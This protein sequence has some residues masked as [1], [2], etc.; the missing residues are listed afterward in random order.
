MLTSF[1]CSLDHHLRNCG[2]DRS[3]SEH[4]EFAGSRGSETKAKES[5][6][7]GKGAKKNAVEPLSVAGQGEA[8]GVKAARGSFSTST[9]MHSLVLYNNA[10][11]LEGTRLT[12]SGMHATVTFGVVSSGDGR[13]HIESSVKHGS[14]TH[15]CGIW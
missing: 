3:I 4:R 5:R 7:D 2:Q 15:W 1:Q 6:K 13:E 9:S 11:W 10:F 8:V 14:K 12:S